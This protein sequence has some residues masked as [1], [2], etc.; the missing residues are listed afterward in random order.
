MTAP[1]TAVLAQLVVDGT[2]PTTPS[3]CAPLF[4]WA[5]GKRW[6]VPICGPAIHAYLARSGGRYIEPFMGGAALAL[7]L[8]EAG[9]LLG[10]IERPL[11]DA[12]RAV[13]DDPTAVARELARFARAGTDRDAY[14]KTRA[15][16]PRSAARR[17]ARLLY[18]NRLAFNG[19]YRVNQAGRFNVPF[20][21]Y[22]KP[23]FPTLQ[24]LEQ[25]A[26][27]LA[28]ARLHVGDFEALV[29]GA[30]E[31]D[32][33]FGDP[34]YPGGFHAYSGTAFDLADHQRLARALQAAAR[35]GAAVVATNADTDDLRAWYAWAQIV[36]T[37]EARAI[38]C[39]GAARQ[40]ARCLLVTTHTSLVWPTDS[41]GRVL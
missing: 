10:D 17:A 9:A 12:Y 28:P 4:K 20:G 26:V 1:S 23:S 34:P 19:L 29:A 41:P 31:G 6:L 13:A 8:G 33:V 3:R 39:K 27:A 2:A 37:V 11:V 25:T 30:G 40:P 16:Q 21:R 18:L 5:G 38:S 14:E 35:R 22:P 15:C 36:P 24:Q 7:W 32:V